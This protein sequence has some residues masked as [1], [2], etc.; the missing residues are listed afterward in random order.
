[1]DN[2]FSFE[3]SKYHRKNLIKEFELNQ[4]MCSLID[5]ESKNDL[6]LNATRFMGNNMTY[7]DLIISSDKLAQALHTIGTKSTLIYVLSSILKMLNPFMPYVT[8]EIYNSLPVKDAESIIISEY[9][10]YNK[11]LVFSKEEKEIDALN[12]IIVTI[13]NAKSAN[14]IPKGFSI[15]N[16]FK[17]TDKYIIDNNIDVLTKLL[18]CDIINSSI[19]GMT[20]IKLL[21]SYGTIVLSYEGSNV[22]E[23]SIEALNKEK[24]TLLN[25]IERRR[26]L[27]ANEKY[28]SNAPE[29]I[30][31]SERQKLQEE[32][33]KL[34]T[35][36]TKL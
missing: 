3:Y 21:F 33:E 36:T 23:E 18:K 6:N 7:G 5:N 11:L 26:K 20:E 31:V 35:L 16:K 25:S 17:D 2:N 32:E 30:V 1:M 34:K 22:S 12:N 4:T 8:D 28:V 24:E 9:P 13:R 19:E 27:L 14:N 15:I 10:E 29:S